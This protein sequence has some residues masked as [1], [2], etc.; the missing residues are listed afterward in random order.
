MILVY[1]LYVQCYSLSA[2]CAVLQPPMISE[3][4]RHDTYMT[5]VDVL[6]NMKTIFYW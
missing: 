4:E 3:P 2:M 6:G 5:T 1:I